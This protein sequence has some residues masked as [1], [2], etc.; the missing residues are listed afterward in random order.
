L[1]PA[2]LTENLRVY[3]TAPANSP[4][5]TAARTDVRFWI[6]DVASADRVSKDTIFTGKGD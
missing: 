5:A 4:A 1:V 3:L 2:D 6:E